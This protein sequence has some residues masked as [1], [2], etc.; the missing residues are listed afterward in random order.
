MLQSE[1]SEIVVKLVQL[2]AGAVRT[3]ENDAILY[4]TDF[5][6]QAQ[7]ARNRGIRE[8]DKAFLSGDVE[9]L[10]KFVTAALSRGLSVG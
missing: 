1:I 7:K 9:V 10:G 8:I 2:N 4:L 6:K 5:P 3:G